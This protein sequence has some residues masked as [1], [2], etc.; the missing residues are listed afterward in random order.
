MSHLHLEI[1]DRQDLEQVMGYAS[2]LSRPVVKR[3]SL[4]FSMLGK[5]REQELEN[6]LTRLF[7]DC[8]CLWGAPGFFLGCGLSLLTHLQGAGFSWSAVGV[9]ALIGVGSA[10]GAKLIGLLW[11]FW[12]L[13][14]TLTQL[15]TKLPQA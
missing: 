4:D 13:Q 15:K 11:S 8:G 5:D 7:N 14:K 2:W 9:S 10:L 3:V 1:K 6:R 12:Q